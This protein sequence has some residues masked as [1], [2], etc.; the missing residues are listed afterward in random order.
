MGAFLPDSDE[1]KRLNEPLSDFLGGQTSFE[2]TG[3]CEVLGELK[4][5]RKEVNQ[6]R[7][8]EAAY[9][10]ATEHREKVAERRGFIKGF[11]SSLLAAVLA[12]LIL[13]YWPDIAACFVAL[14]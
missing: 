4:R 2:D 1:F 10:S 13:Y 3:L 8:D 12:G 5:L 11:F 9:Q 6:Y 7:A 14:S